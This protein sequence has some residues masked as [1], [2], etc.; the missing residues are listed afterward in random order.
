MARTIG[1]V[2]IAGWHI[3]WIVTGSDRSST[4]N[5][6]NVS[7][8]RRR[9]HVEPSIDLGHL[10]S[11][12]LGA[13]GELAWIADGRVHL[14]H[15]GE[16]PPGI[17]GSSTRASR[18]AA[19]ASPRAAVRWRPRDRAPPR[20]A[21][22]AAPAAVRQAVSARRRSRSCSA[23]T[24]RPAGARPAA[25]RRLASGSATSCTTHA[26]R[27]VAQRR[28]AGPYV[29]VATRERRDPLRLRDGSARS[30]SRPTSPL[31]AGRRA[32]R[33]LVDRR[34]PGHHRAW[35]SDGDGS[36]RSDPRASAPCA[37]GRRSAGVDQVLQDEA[38]QRRV[39]SR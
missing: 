22:R 26:R 10:A 6:L 38:G 11:W 4:W 25:S 37:T 35:V 7:D 39:S 19:C 15:P 31:A 34:P 12:D 20:A 1:S 32:R 5:N 33:A 13:G 17:R 36:T 30:A 9:G 29:A 14:W 21:W 16:R 8:V 28:H 24:R 23:P 3:A 2:R 27:P 18:C